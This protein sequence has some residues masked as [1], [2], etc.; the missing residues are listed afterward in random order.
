[1]V[2]VMLSMMIF[3]VMIL[4]FGAVFP[5]ALHT[6]A[7]S[8]NYAQAALVA[9]HKIDQLQNAGY[10][11]MDYNDLSSLGIIDTSINPNSPYTFTGVDNL[12]GNGG[13]PGFFA[14]GS[15]GIVTIV[16]YNTLNPGVLPGNMAYATVTIN[17]TSYTGS[18]GTYSTSIIL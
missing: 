1:M 14:T 13:N 15:A 18:V 10:A 5:F 17:W 4:V 16:D 6:A 8:N 7:F 12:V 11:R 9:Q 2:E 3:V